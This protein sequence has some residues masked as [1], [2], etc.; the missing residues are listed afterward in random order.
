MQKSVF[1]FL[2]V[3]ILAAN[4]SPPCA[5]A[6]LD[7]SSLLYDGGVSALGSADHSYWETF[8][9]GVTGTLVDVDLGFFNGISGNP[10]LTGTGEFEIFSGDPP[11]GSPL[12]SRDVSVFAPG[13]S[14]LTM[15]SFAVHV[16]ITKGN[17]YAFEFTPIDMPFVFGIG[18]G[19]VNPDDPAEFYPPYSGGHAGLTDPSGIYPAPDNFVFETY[20]SPSVPEPSSTVLLII[21]I[22]CLLVTRLRR[23]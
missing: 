12:A 21:S 7:Q 18:I 16:P 6:I 15:N 13:S 23:A 9:A 8:T 11:F 10:S 1:G 4:V 20:V 14:P 17:V 2:A 5:S 19:V 3:T 22:G